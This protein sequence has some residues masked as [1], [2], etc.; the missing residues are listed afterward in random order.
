MSVANVLIELGTEELPPKALLALRDAFID[1]VVQQLN[2]A[3]FAHGEVERFA[4]P[5]RLAFR[6][7]QLALRQPD[8][9]LEKRGPAVQAAFDKDGKPT[10]ALEGF[11]KSA[12]VE[13]DQLERLSTD[14]GE[15]LVAKTLQKGQALEAVLQGYLE[16]AIHKL[17][18]PKRMH[19]GRSRVQFVRPVHWLV[20]LQDNKIIPIGLLG[21]TSDRL[22]RGHRFHH[23]DQISLSHA[24]DY[25][26]VL[27]T[28]GKVMPVFEK[29]REL[30]AK[31]SIELA[32]KEGG[33]IRMLP[34]LLDEVTSLVEWPVPLVAHFEERF[35]RVPQEALIAT[36]ES[37]QK[38]FAVMDANGK[39][40]NAFVFVSNIESK[41]PAQVIAGNEKVVRPRLSDAEFFYDVDC[42]KTLAQH[43]EP[44]A[45]V[46]FQQQLGTVAEKSERVAK[47]AAFISAQLGGD[48][49]LVEQAGVLAKADLTT[50][51]VGEFDNMQGVM[52]RYLALNE[53]LSPE[54][55]QAIE[56]QYLPRFS[57]D[58]LPS[59]KTGQAL[60]L[61]DKLFTLMGIFGIGQKPTGDKDPFALRRQALGVLRIIIECQLPLSLKQLVD[62]AAKL[63]ADRI[64]ANA[65]NDVLEFLAGRYRN[66]YQEQGFS[67]QL[68]QAVAAVHPE[69]P[70]DLD[71]RLRALANFAQQPACA[72]L[73]A[74][75]KRVANILAKQDGAISEQI[76]V[77]LLQEPAE[78]D[79]AQV[80]SQQQSLG[81]RADEASYLTQL[82]K[83]ADL[84]EPVDAFFEQVMVNADDAALRANRL[85]I[86][87]KL[88]SLFMEVADI[89]LLD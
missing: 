50:G 12:G 8:R 78:K 32:E 9:E 34:S 17:P 57:G 39:L 2:D 65:A 7:N 49:A 11:A 72:A 6:I 88:R 80:L 23:P 68:I 84:R 4:A 89:S 31:R 46:V 26:S 86:L 40:K 74:A 58:A 1:E 63:L 24:N 44:L 16:Q 83:L 21:L 77:S 5:R 51:M 15:W 54:L 25:E 81:G 10:R 76:D 67:T 87:A 82:N 66:H 22:T 61:A 14:K 35:L 48:K 62:E 53:G 43:A 28:T 75:N 41:D 73:A 56:E 55:A 70:L 37:D 30:I 59:S 3:G 19:W 33:N 29:R 69:L 13:I 71:Y 85:A 20:A 45:K 42:K 18:I 60:A 64:E 52:G 38:Y 27:E 79:L 47:L 36:M